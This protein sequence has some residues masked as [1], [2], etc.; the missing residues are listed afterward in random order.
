M[1][2]CLRKLDDI[3]TLGCIG[4]LAAGAVT[5]K[6]TSYPKRRTIRESLAYEKKRGNLTEEYEALPKSAYTITCSDGCSLHATFVPAEDASSKKFVIFTHGHGYTRFGALAFIPVFRSLGFNSI[7]YDNRGCGENE[8]RAITLGVRERYD[9]SDVIDDTRRRYGEDVAIG[10]HGVSQGAA[11][12]NMVLGLRQ[13]IAF[14]ISDCGYSDLLQLEKRILANMFIPQF[15]AYIASSLSKFFVGFHF[16]EC[17]P[18]HEIVNNRVPVCY[19]HGDADDYVACEHSKM[20]A[21]VNPAYTELHLF[22]G[23]GHAAA[24]YSD[25]ER[26]EKI[27]R[28]FLQ[29]I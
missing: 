20:M 18:I 11:T 6:R 24:Y 26:Y 3:C 27:V 29:R 15:V 10:L 19:I 25:P 21:R 8:P 17:S 9:L 13:D 1:S 12:S 28:E 2:K 23:A 4:L 5:V 7:M 22:P 16:A 14:V